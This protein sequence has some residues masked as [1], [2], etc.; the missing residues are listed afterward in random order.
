MFDTY[1]NYPN[2]GSLNLPF[3]ITTGA[4]VVAGEAVKLDGTTGKLIKCDGTAGEMTMVATKDQ[5]DNWVEDGGKIECL[6][7][8]AVF[9]TD[10]F[11]STS[12]VYGC[13][14]EVSAGTPGKFKIYNAA[15]KVGRYLGTTT[16]VNPLTGLDVTMAIIALG[17]NL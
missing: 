5:T 2:E 4:G 16:V 17:G 7:G 14:V 6:M 10:K 9:C 3:P 11:I 1:K 15:N 8:N 13:L 12:L